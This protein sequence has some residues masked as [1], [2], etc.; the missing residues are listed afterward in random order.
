[1]TSGGPGAGEGTE[2]GSP[3]I[4]T[5][6]F[7]LLLLSSFVFQSGI[8]F[9][10][11]TLPLFLRHLG[12]GEAI[13]GVI[14]GVGALASLTARVTFADAVDRWGRAE[15]M[16][17]ACA[18]AACGAAALTTVVDETAVAP[19]RVL[20]A[21]AM[22]L[23]LT[24]STTAAADL[25]PPARRGEAM[26][27]FGFAGPLAMA[28]GPGLGG[29][30]LDAWGFAAAFT[31]TLVAAVLAGVFAVPLRRR[32]ARVAVDRNR[33]RPTL[34][35]RVR[36]LV[37]PTALVPGVFVL[38]L[39]LTNGAVFAFVP[40]RADA[41]GIGNVGLFFVCYAAAMLTARSVSGRISD[42]LGRGVAILPGI[43]VAAVG[44]VGIAVAGSAEELLVAGAVFGAGL[45]IG[46]P[47][48]TAW[49]VDR[50]AG[51]RRGSAVNTMLMAMDVGIATGS[52]I[53]G[54]L[55]GP[56]GFTVA[57]LL[58][59]GLVAATAPVFA[60]LWLRGNG[61]FVVRAARAE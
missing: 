18:V 6:A 37:E 14:M 54:A 13:I 17:L 7:T 27:W 15:V 49:V 47:A 38:A 35:Q 39:V 1:M 43:V 46:N 61:R 23:F 9:L 45:G 56:V 31:G 51:E 24:A 26:G 19:L 22:A 32:L 57:F 33:Q 40:L 28:V 36:N 34:T 30:L 12:S 16:L 53:V 21:A 60:Y 29:W 3:P 41:I 52:A 4:W 20:V 5:P 44:L 2:L 55:L 50:A 10:V 58:L 11:P 59:A 48:L 25:A 42:R 8:H